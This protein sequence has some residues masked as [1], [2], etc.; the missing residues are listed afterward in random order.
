MKFRI[1]GTADDSIVDGDGVRYTI[2][3]Q[4]CPHKCPGCHNPETHNFHGGRDATTEEMVAAIR[5]NPLLSG[6]TFSGG[7]P[8]TQPEPLT[9]IAKAVHDMHLD[10]WCYTGYK[11]EELIALPNPAVHELL[12]NID[13][14]VDGPF[15]I[16]KRD[17]TLSFRGSSNQRILCLKNLRPKKTL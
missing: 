10:V 4:G 3:V 16:Q 14:L 6:V 5:K 13:V 7:E 8:F 1:A 9:E 11:Y 12:D 15:E 2:F 17:L